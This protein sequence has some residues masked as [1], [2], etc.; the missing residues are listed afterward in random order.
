MAMQLSDE[1][2]ILLFAIVAVPLMIL[3]VLLYPVVLLLHIFRIA[4]EGGLIECIQDKIKFNKIVDVDAWTIEAHCLSF[5][6]M[7]IAWGIKR[8]KD[9]YALP[10]LADALQDADCRKD[11]VLYFLRHPNEFGDVDFFAERI[12]QV[13]L[14]N[15]EKAKRELKAK[16]PHV[17]MAPANKFTCNMPEID[18]Q[19]SSSE[20]YTGKYL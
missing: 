18:F 5:N 20:K 14:V 13:I 16:A 6:V 15:D 1:M 8:N 12:L 17:R 7:T 11:D 3:I 9:Y 4:G 19:T 2:K 10:I